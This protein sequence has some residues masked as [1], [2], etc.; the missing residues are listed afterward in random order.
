MRSKIYPY[1]KR[2]NKHFSEDKIRYKRIKMQD[3][4]K[5]FREELETGG[6][7]PFQDDIENATCECIDN[8]EKTSKLL[9]GMQ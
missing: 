1:F 3:L 2:A 9:V 6:A 5:L 8:L 7:P 4:D